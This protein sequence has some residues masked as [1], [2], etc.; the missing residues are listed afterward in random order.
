MVPSKKWKTAVPKV[1]LSLED[2]LA[3]QLKMVM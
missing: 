2:F 3:L 1:R